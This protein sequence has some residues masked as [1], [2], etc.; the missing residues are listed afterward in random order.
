L[1]GQLYRREIF[2]AQGGKFNKELIISDLPAGLLL[3]KV[4][5]GET[6]FLRKLIRE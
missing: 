2:Q 6:S 4:D 5:T 3:I 1:Q